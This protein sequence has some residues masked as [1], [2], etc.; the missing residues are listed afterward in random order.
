[1]SKRY[2]RAPKSK[3]A[4]FRTDMLWSGE[5]LH[6]IYNPEGQEVFSPLLPRQYLQHNQVSQHFFMVIS[7]KLRFFLWRIF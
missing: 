5:C 1:M 3:N 2:R 4:Y 7:G 6:S